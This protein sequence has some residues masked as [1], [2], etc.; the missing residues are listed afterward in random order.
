MCRKIIVHGVFAATAV[1]QN[2]I[3][4]PIISVDNSAADVATTGC[5]SQHHAAIRSCEHRSRKAFI[6]V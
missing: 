5:L 6:T 4:L 1:R 2:M 3:R